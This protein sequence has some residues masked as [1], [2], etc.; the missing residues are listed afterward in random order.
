M[1]EAPLDIHGA[2]RARLADLGLRR[3]DLAARCQAIRPLRPHG[4][5]EQISRLLGPDSE[6]RDGGCKIETLAVILSAL[7][8]G[9]RPTEKSTEP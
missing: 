4:W 3:T 6:P 1:T 8:L 9:L 7:G 2:I 5:L